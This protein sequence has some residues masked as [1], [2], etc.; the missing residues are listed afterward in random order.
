MVVGGR[1]VEGPTVVGGR[2]VGGP[3]VVGGRDVG[4]P[5]VM[6]GRDVGGPMVTVGRVVGGVLVSGVK[7]RE[8]NVIIS[9][10]LMASPST[11]APAVVQ[12]S[13]HTHQEAVYWG[14]SQ[15]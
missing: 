6:G 13:D 10:L 3:M 8:M 1:D 2:D 14:P 7:T 5:V 9:A 15:Q 11:E 4:G 12:Y